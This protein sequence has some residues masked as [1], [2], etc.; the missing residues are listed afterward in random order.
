MS[1]RSL[2]CIAA[3][4]GLM[5][6]VAPA[7]VPPDKVL[8]TF[9]VVDGLQLELFAAEPMLV[10]PTCIDIDHKGR[11]W[12]CEAV[13]YRRINFGR[14]IL[15]PE[16]DRIVILEDTDGDGKADKSTV[17][18]Q[19]KD[20]YGPM[21]IAVA[22]DPIGPG[23]KVFV[24]Q[25]PDILVFTDSKGEGKADGP[26]K[27]LLSGFGGFDHDH[28]VHGVLIGPDMKLYFSVGD[29]GVKGLQSSDGKGR[30][31]TSNDTD[32]QAGT[33]W[34]C[35]LDG[36]NLELIAHNFRNEYE[37]CVDSFGTVFVSDNDD[38]GNQQTRICYVMPGG[39]YG[40][41]MKPKKVSHWNE[42][43]PGVV[44]K[45]LRTYFGSPTGMCVY[46]GTLLPKKY[47]G[48][49]LHTDAG[50]RHLRCYHLTPK[51]AGY[52]VERED[53]VT[54]DKDTWFRPSDVCVAP[55][56]S[57]F[58]A[59]WYDPGVG[60]H[61]MGDWTRGRIYRVT[62]AG[63]KG[64]KVPEVK[65]DSPKGIRE[66]LASPALSA[67]YM[68]MARLEQMKT[69]DVVDC[70]HLLSTKDNLPFVRARAIWQ[71][72][73]R[74]KRKE[75]GWEDKLGGAGVGPEAEAFQVLAVRALKDFLG[76][77]YADIGGPP[78]NIAAA[79]PLSAVRREILLSLRDVELIKAEP[80]I[81]ALARQYDGKDRF[82]LEAIGIAVGHWDKERRD[83]ILKDFDKE[84]PE[85]NDKVADLV[86]ELQPPS[87]MPTL[88]KLLSDKSLSSSSRARIIDVLA[89]SSEPS[90]GKTLLQLLP[91]DAPAEVHDRVLDNL[92]QHL[93]GKWREL[94]KTQEFT[95][96]LNALLDRLDRRSDAL[97]LIVAAQKTD[98]IVAVEQ[99]ANNP[100]NGD[101]LRDD[102]VL[103]LGALPTVEAVKD[104]R[105]VYL[106]TRPAAAIQ[107]LGLHARRRLDQPDAKAALE[108]LQGLVQGPKQKDDWRIAALD[109]LAGS[110]AGSQWLLAANDKKQ[111]PDEL[112]PQ[113]GRLLRNSPYPDL[114]NRALLTF[115][116][117]GKIDPKKLPSIPVL[118]GRRGDVARGKALLAGS[119]KGDMQCLKCHT[120]RG[121]GGSI[122][123]DLSMI[124]KK[125]SRENL[126]ES[127]VF[128]SKAIADQ[129]INWNIETK[130]G[131]TITGLIVDEARDHIV[132]RDAN[133]KDT[134]IDAA[135]ID[136]RTKNPSS[137]MP[138]DIVA[139]MTESELIDVVEYL[140]TLKT[141]S[142]TF[143]SWLIAGPFENGPDRAGLER[144]LPPEKGI[145][146]AATYDGKSGKVTWRTVRASAGNYFDLQAF[147]GAASP[148]SVSYVYR[149]IESP[150]DQEATILLG[151]DDGCKLWLNDRLVFTSHAT[152]AAAPE[153]DVVKVTLRKGK[154]KI[155]LKIDN[156]GD[157]HGFYFTVESPEELKLTPSDSR[158][159]GPGRAG[160]PR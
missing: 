39:N 111:L 31:W 20:L 157:P 43:V 64:Y 107:A 132:L 87:M 19:G 96:T 95:D 86:W 28:G 49:L 135:D 148:H 97:A 44:P 17:F 82:Y 75:K 14:P 112:K 134:H 8:P 18:Y 144:V 116:L 92:K 140:L 117:P 119:L 150:V 109:A 73:R 60:G 160:L 115:P 91:S 7:Q 155:L 10:N 80:Y 33:I 3:I 1:L 78:K 62:P 121:Q 156:G 22:K 29:Q 129:Y 67:R 37:P 77:T 154:N 149:Q 4:L 65:L 47:W 54:N 15:R 128:P 85:W 6:T 26:P 38:D 74:A 104:L 133:G 130:K 131:L 158:G 118:A 12:V 125:A 59:D 108:A 141:P 122:G 51:G 98:A 88:G 94:S 114:R 101:K 93:P 84:F 48:Q 139:S 36:T 124:G 50:P 81:L 41:H 53:M 70:L 46:E 69:Q 113:V 2:F 153:Q 16:G 27:K 30:K 24:C 110:R 66:A 40:Y 56:G 123:P 71:L 52:D 9:H 76:V 57:V 102:A 23:Y 136:S 72:A 5:P 42:E 99:V 25:S 90:A 89:A 21:G 79:I 145:D 34:R 138:N 147:H 143:D 45:I 159:T 127:M 105:D 146:L 137:L 13:N 32:C 142:L 35:D 83:I 100:V 126:I 58:V 63:H 61:G 120:I 55:D 151:T 11:V 106:K 68:A 152:R 103:A